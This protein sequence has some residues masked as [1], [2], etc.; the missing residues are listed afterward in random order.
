MYVREFYVITFSLFAIIIIIII[1][2]INYNVAIKV[3]FF[4]RQVLLLLLFFFFPCADNAARGL[5]RI[6]VINQRSIREGG[7]FIILC[8]QNE[9][10]KDIKRLGRKKKRNPKYNGSIYRYW[11]ILNREELKKQEKENVGKKEE[12]KSAD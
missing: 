1:I 8:I 7:K 9:K 2:S 12:N 10:R 6:I 11:H 4:L 5:K 3:C